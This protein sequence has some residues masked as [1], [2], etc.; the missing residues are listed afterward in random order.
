MRRE[1]PHGDGST[2]EAA[3]SGAGAKPKQRAEAQKASL[4]KPAVVTVTWAAW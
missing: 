2:P 4:P 1:Q 3:S